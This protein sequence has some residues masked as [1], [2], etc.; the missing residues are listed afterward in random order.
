MV[1]DYETGIYYSKNWNDTVGTYS[2]SVIPDDKAAVE[3]ATAIYNSIPKRDEAQEWTPQYVFYDEQ[4]EIWIVSFWKTSDESLMGGCC[5]IALQKQ[6]AKVL[7]IWY[8][9]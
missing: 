5:S 9:E 7:R 6:D 3:I 2:G 1:I 8:G 4:D